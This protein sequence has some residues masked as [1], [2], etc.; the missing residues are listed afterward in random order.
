[1]V[2]REIAER[3]NVFAAAAV[4]SVLPFFVPGGRQEIRLYAAAISA[5]LFAAA[6]SL[7]LGASTIGRDLSEG[8]LGFYFTRPIGSGAIW[9]GKLAAIWLQ[10]VLAAVIMLLP[11][12]VFD[13]SAWWRETRSGGLVGDV[14]LAFAFA[15]LVFLA[16]GNVVS[17]AFRAR[18]FWVAGDLVCL[19]LWGLA[20]WF[21]A[22]PLLL[23]GAPV[24]TLRVALA[25][26][27]ACSVALLAAGGAQVA[28]GRVDA[29]RGGRAR[30]AVLWVLLFALAG[31]AFVSVRWLLSPAPQDL[32]DRGIEAAAPR[33]SWIAIEGYARGRVD[34]R[35]SLFY[36]IASGR[37]SGAGRGA[38]ARSRSPATERR[39]RGLS[40]R[41][42]TRG[43]LDVWICRSPPDKSARP[44]PIP[45][46]REHRDVAERLSARGHGKRGQRLRY[47]PA[48]SW[49][50]PRDSSGITCASCF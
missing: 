15:V 21:A 37:P 39:R 38:R 22:R 7:L 16:V 43:A 48:A 1:V 42:S 25:T 46:G 49:S 13:F 45:E 28:V 3:R 24:L 11:V 36:D 32:R 40:A 34:L 44:T 5:V 47:R 20:M 27:A 18:S 8:R 31:L 9:A 6:I 17:L 33:G 10:A 26:L 23:A 2:R 14:A 41:A 29:V 12:G 19:A 50:A 4:C 35:A 30:F